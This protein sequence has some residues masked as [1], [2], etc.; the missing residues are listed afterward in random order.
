VDHTNHREQAAKGPR[1]AK[2]HVCQNCFDDVFQEHIR[3]KH[4]LYMK[5]EEYQSPSVDYIVVTMSDSLDDQT[6]HAKV[7]S[8]HLYKQTKTDEKDDDPKL[9]NLYNLVISSTI[10]VARTCLGSFR[11]LITTW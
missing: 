3:H 4:H 6:T 5:Q 1:R 10:L 7:C 2:R 9:S 11:F 8:S